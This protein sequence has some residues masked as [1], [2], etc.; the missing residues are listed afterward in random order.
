MSHILLVEDDKDLS[1]I[2]KIHLTG[3]GH[4]VRQAFL[5]E[6]A[7]TFIDED[8]FDLVLLDLMIPDGNG[9]DLCVYL[10]RRDFVPVIFMSCLEDSVTI[11]SSLAKGGDDYVTKPVDYDELLARID[12]NIRRFQS[13]SGKGK[14]RDDMRR[15]HGVT[16]DTLRHRVI[17]DTRE[18]GLTQIEYALFEYLS[19]RPNELIL[20]DDLY[21]S[22]WGNESFGDFRTLIVHMSNL[23]KKINPNIRGMIENV[24]GVG[25]FFTDV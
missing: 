6:E 12:A 3:A 9:Q 19:A 25:Y 20:Y 22:V 16:V 7:K 21:R 2:T 18:V 15:F 13:M 1:E 5:C 17:I 23:R 11:V 8:Y 4:T 24:R 10:R 14:R